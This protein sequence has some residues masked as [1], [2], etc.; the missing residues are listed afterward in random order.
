MTELYRICAPDAAVIIHVPDPRHSNF[1]NDPTH[2]RPITPAILSLFSRERND[3]WREGGAANTPLAL[4][5]GTDFKIASHEALLAE[6]YKSQAAAR[7]LTVQALGDAYAQFNNVVEEW[8][9]NLTVLKA[10]A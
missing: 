8:R 2:V 10:P 4:Y 1:L 5:T 6:P 9:F 7:T 3:E